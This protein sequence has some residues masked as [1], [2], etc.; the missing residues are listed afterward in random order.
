M[1]GRRNAEHVPE[2][3]D[4][5]EQPLLAG[6]PSGRRHGVVGGHAD[7]LVIDLGVEVAGDEAGAD[8]LDRVRALGPT[9]QDGRGVGLDRDD[10]HLGTALLE[11]LAHAGDGAAR[12]HAR[13]DDVDLAVGVGPDLLGGGAPVD[14]RVG[15]VLELLGDERR[16]VVLGDLGRLGDGA[17]HAVGSGCEHEL[18]A[19]GLEQGAPLDAHGLGHGE[20]Q[21][22]P[23][24][25][26]HHRQG[27]AGVAAGR[28]DD[29]RV[30]ADQAG[31]LGGV[32]H[33]DA[34]PVLHGVGG[35]EVL[36]LGGDLAVGALGEA[37]DP[38]QGRVADQVRDAGCDLHAGNARTRRLAL[39]VAD[40]SVTRAVRPAWGPSW[41][42]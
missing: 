18:G 38:D 30:G 1:R 3:R 7:D 16:R 19:V 28:L 29:H 5:D 25:R 40:Q 13:D 11:H 2:H 41:S 17:A 32:D 39:S 14:G 36:E 10:L 20:D 24:G 42:R 27:D 31:L 4:A 8:A 34:D 9:G 15:G 22:D 37:V 6:G 23:A 35:V 21:L 26:A 33:R 12:A